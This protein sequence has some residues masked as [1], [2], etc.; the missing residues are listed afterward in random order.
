MGRRYEEGILPF[1]I[2]PTDEPLVARSGLLLPYEMAKGLKLP[3]VI[4]K[5]LP[6]RVVVEDISHLALS[7]L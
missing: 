7:C 1:R 6:H 4:D 3:E 2:V 5:E